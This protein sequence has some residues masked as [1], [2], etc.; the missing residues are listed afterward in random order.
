MKIVNII[1]GC[2]W[3]F[4]GISALAGVLNVTP[5]LYFVAT[6]ALAFEF[7]MDQN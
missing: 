6:L 4:L 3:L 5:G 1:L 2:V 7:F